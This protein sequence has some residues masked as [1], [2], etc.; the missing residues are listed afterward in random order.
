[1]KKEAASE[2]SGARQSVI[3]MVTNNQSFQALANDD[4]LIPSQSHPASESLRPKTV[5]HSSSGVGHLKVIRTLSQLSQHSQHSFDEHSHH[6]SSHLSHLPKSTSRN[7]VIG[8]KSAA[9]NFMQKKKLNKSH[10]HHDSAQDRGLK[11]IPYYGNQKIANTL[12]KLAQARLLITEEMINP[13][14][15]L[16]NEMLTRNNAKDNDS[17][18]ECE[19]YHNSAL[20]DAEIALQITPNDINITLVCVVCYIRLAQY[21][22]AS[23]LL[24]TLL[25]DQPGQKKGLYYRAFCYRAVN[26]SLKAIECLTKVLIFFPCFISLRSSPKPSKLD[27]KEM[28]IQTKKRR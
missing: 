23:T 24:D 2:N 28:K 1:L 13:P 8:F 7:S 5:A 4:S 27:L 16:E 9:S 15:S 22:R 6:S 25:S 12:I 14:E 18:T 3:N 26:N 19:E 11:K 21:D 20:H 10:S 17:L